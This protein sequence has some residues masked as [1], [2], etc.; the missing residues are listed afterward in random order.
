MNT[1]FFVFGSLF[2]DPIKNAFKRLLRLDVFCLFAY[3]SFCTACNIA[4]G[5]KFDLPRSVRNYS[6]TIKKYVAQNLHTKIFNL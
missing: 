1:I 6:S 3:V 2:L 4:Y 5:S